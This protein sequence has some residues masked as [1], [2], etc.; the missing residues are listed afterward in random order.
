MKADSQMQSGINLDGWFAGGVHF[1]PLRVNFEDTDAGGI[2]YHANYL[3]FAERARSAC[4]RCLGICQEETLVSLQ[5]GNTEAF[6]FVVRRVTVDYMRAAGLGEALLV[7]TCIERLRG[8]SM[9]LQ[10]TVTNFEDGHILAR[11]VVDIGC[12]APT[13]GGGK[14]PRRIP[15]A[16][17]DKLSQSVPA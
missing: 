11:L 4:L 9:E 10:Q 2:V 6:I 16:V 7:E 13:V 12:V 14:R 17:V 3:A 15:G 1:Y 5:D 8:A